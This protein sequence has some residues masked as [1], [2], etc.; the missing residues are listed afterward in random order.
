[1]LFGFLACGFLSLSISAII[2]VNTSKLALALSLSCIWSLL[3][4]SSIIKLLVITSG[5]S[6]PSVVVLSPTLSSD[7]SPKTSFFACSSGTGGSVGVGVD[8]DGEP[9]SLGLSIGG[10]T[11]AIGP[12]PPTASAANIIAWAAC[13]PGSA[14]LAVCCPILLLSAI[15]EAVGTEPPGAKFIGDCF[16]SCCPTNLSKSITTLD[17]NW[18]LFFFLAS[19]ILAASTIAS[20]STS[21]DLRSSSLSLKFN[22][23]AVFWASIPFCTLSNS[24]C[25]FC[26]LRFCCSILSNPPCAFNLLASRICLADS[27]IIIPIVAPWS[28]WPSWAFISPPIC[29]WNLRTM[30]SLIL[31]NKTGVTCFITGL[32]PLSGS[33]T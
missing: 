1:M 7:T 22:S 5:T 27:D 2:S 18:S 4:A 25:C 12:L 13:I 10:A 15:N 30:C 23:A 8:I 29:S 20:M 16:A 17:V 9:M 6:N 28:T 31:A 11:S 26:K 19:S 24:S 21:L 32:A 14:I 33:C 3:K